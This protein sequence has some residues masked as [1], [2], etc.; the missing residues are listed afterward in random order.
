[1]A[2]CGQYTPLTFYQIDAKRGQDGMRTA[3]ILPL[4]QGTAV[5]D[6]WA[7]Y[8]A[9]DHCQHA[10]CNAHHLCANCNSWLNNISSPG[11]PTWH[12]LAGQQTRSRCRPTKRHGFTLPA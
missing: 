1:M 7:S 11:L 10:F 3:G 8:L 9:F 12:N 4:F 2:A 6:H 5:H